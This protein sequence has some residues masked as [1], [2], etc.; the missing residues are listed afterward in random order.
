MFQQEAVRLYLIK[1]GVETESIIN[2]STRNLES[3]RGIYVAAREN[4]NQ[5]GI[6]NKV[7]ISSAPFSEVKAA[8]ANPKNPNTEIDLERNSARPSGL[9]FFGTRPLEAQ[10]KQMFLK[11]K[12]MAEKEGLTLVF[13]D[14]AALEKEYQASKTLETK[15]ENER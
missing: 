10:N 11:A 3:N 15:K 7:S 9:C 14:T 13:V 4:F 8:E 6:T 2:I 1:L 5:R 12:E